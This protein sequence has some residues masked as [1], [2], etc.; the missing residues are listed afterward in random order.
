MSR[1]ARS[2][3]APRHVSLAA[4]L[5]DRV[6]D[7]L[8]VMRHRELGRDIGSCQRCGKPVRSQQNFM[9]ENGAVAHVRCR[10][11]DPSQ[12]ARMQ[13]DARLNAPLGDA[14]TLKLRR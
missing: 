13:L 2:D 6:Q 3:E 9:R 7:H 11:T 8:A 5:L 14:P 10:I 1:Q 4:A 12:G